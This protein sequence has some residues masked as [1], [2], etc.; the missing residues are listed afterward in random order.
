MAEE[1]ESHPPAPRKTAKQERDERL[2]AELR[3]NL[4]RRKDQTRGRDATSPASGDDGS[5]DAG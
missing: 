3:A 2:A 5:R 4:R 1:P